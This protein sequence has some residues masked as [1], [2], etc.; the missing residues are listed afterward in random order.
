MTEGEYIRAMTA[1]ILSISIILIGIGVGLTVAKHSKHSDSTA[2]LDW[3][4]VADP[5]PALTD[6]HWAVDDPLYDGWSYT[7]KYDD[8]MWQVQETVDGAV[9]RILNEDD[10]D[11][12][13]F[14]TEDGAKLFVEQL[15]MAH[16]VHATEEVGTNPPKVWTANYPTIVHTMPSGKSPSIARLGDGEPVQLTGKTEDGWL[17]VEY[18]D[19]TGW[20]YESRGSVDPDLDYPGLDKFMERI[21][22]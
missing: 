13:E 3:Q 20:V 7:V 14:N 16:A 6:H 4:R 2:L 17:E 9:Q 1:N 22:Y 8:P 5:L 18:L 12:R 19:G 21:G 10:D 11:F 15:V